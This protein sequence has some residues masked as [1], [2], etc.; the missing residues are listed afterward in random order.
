MSTQ[1]AIL[2]GAVSALLSGTAA[3]QAHPEKPTYPYEKCYG[4]AAAGQNDCFTPQNSCAG[5]SEQDRELQAWIF[6]PKG[7]CTKIAGGRLDSGK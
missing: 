2:I 1:H 5:T 7:T 4:I 3:G 6:V